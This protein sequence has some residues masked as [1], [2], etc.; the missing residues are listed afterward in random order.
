MP[1]LGFAS[2]DESNLPNDPS[3]NLPLF[4]WQEDKFINF[5]DYLSRALVERIVNIPIRCYVKKSLN[6]DQKLLALGSILYFA[7]EGDILW[8][9]GVNGKTQNPKKYNFMHLDVRSVRGPI[10]AKFLRDNF[11]IEAPEIYGDPALLFPYFFPEFKKK[12]NPSREYSIVLHYTDAKSFPKSNY[13]NVIDTAQPWYEIVEQI[14]DSKFIIATALHAIV[15]AEAYGIPA[16]LLRISESAHNH[17]LK[18]HDY[19]QGTGRQYF[20]FAT[21]VEQALSM[22]GEPPFECDLKKL[23]S[24]FPFEFWPNAQFKQPDFLYA[25]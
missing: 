8:G 23:Y 4:Y 2:L 24:A 11:Q 20:Q 18:Y 10:T 13:M 1:W 16:R 12:E 17:I 22:G 9:T 14:L 25:K 7:N 6:Q 19:Y 15:I 5:G 3:K 21:S